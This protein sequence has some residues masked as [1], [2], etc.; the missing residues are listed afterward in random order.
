MPCRRHDDECPSGE[1]QERDRRADQ[2]KDRVDLPRG[3]QPRRVLRRRGGIDPRERDVER[4]VVVG[5]AEERQHVVVEDGLAFGVGQERRLEAGR[6]VELDLAVFER[7]VDLEEDREAVV[8]PASTDAPLVDERPGVCLGLLGRD[9]VV[10]ELRV[11]HDLGRRPCLD[12][13]DGRLGV[14]DRGRREDAGR[15]VHGLALDRRRERRTGGRRHER[16][17]QDGRDGDRSGDRATETSTDTAEVAAT[18][19]MDQAG[20][21][22]AA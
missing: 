20:T 9:A 13:I 4:P 2:P 22:A 7:R 5:V 19:R 15:V 12:R 3:L 8:E 10:D 6:G 1:P 18:T 21:L 16:Q 17:R 11:D 14:L